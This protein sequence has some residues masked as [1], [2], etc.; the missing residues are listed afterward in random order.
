MVRNTGAR[1][2]TLIE[3]MIVMIIIAIL[4]AIAIPLYLGSRDRAKDAAVK[5]GVYDIRVGVLSYAIANES[6][7]PPTGSVNDLLSGTIVSPW[8]LNPFSA[9]GA[10]MSYSSAH[11]D[12]D[13]DYAR[14]GSTY[15]ITGWLSRNGSFVVP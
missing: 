8:P 15:R 7:Y 11:A 1:G 4:A 10:P 9:S 5:E 2:F 14:S 3:M 12:G 13:Y 6:T